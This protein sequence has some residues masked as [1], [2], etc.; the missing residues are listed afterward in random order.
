MGICSTKTEVLT[1]KT[2]SR[3]GGASIGQEPR[4]C[5]KPGAPALGGALIAGV[6]GADLSNRLLESPSRIPMRDG[7][8]WVI[9]AIGGLR[10]LSAAYGH[11]CKQ[12]SKFDQDFGLTGAEG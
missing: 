1:L 8:P 4:K 10:F 3:A 6:A 7:F 9:F 2:K 5:S 12:A 11:P